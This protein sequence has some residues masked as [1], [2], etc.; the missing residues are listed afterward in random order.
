VFDSV[1]NLYGTTFSVGVITCGKSGSGCGVVFELSP[2]GKNWAETVLYS[3]TG[4]TDGA[5]PAAGLIFDPAGNLYGTT[6][7]GPGGSG[8]GAVFELSPSGSGWTEQVIYSPGPPG[9]CCALSTGLTMDSAGSIFGAGESTVFQLSPNGSGG[10]NPTVIYNFPCS[11]KG[12]CPQGRSPQGSPVLDQAGNL[13]GT[14]AYGGAKN[15]GTV[16]KLSPG[17]TGWTETIL[18]SF[19]KNGIDGYYPSAGVVLDAAGN[20][21]GTTSAGG[22]PS[23]CEGLTRGIVFEILAPVGKHKNYKEKVL[24]SFNGYDGSGYDG[25]GSSGLTPDSQGNFYGTTKFGGYWY[26]FD[27]CG[28][29]NGVVFEVTP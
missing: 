15:Y 3:F 19:R 17:E 23:R 9:S 7:F 21:Y 20:V 12:K 28:L 4:G 1:G 27:N 13:Y 10:W 5:D 11:P 8:D 16:Y 18:H 22:P 6:S 24:W 26:G 2:V 25:S 14:T 29:G